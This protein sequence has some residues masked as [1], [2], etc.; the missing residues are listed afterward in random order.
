MAFN[1]YYKDELLFLREMGQEF[2]EAHP[3]AAFLAGRG[4]DPDVERLM[5]GFA[6]LTGR[7]RQKLDDEF[8][9]LTHGMMNVLWPH[10]LRPIPSM[11]IL[12]FSPIGGSVQGR[13][14][15]PRDTEVASVPVDGVPCRFRTTSQVELYP[16]LLDQA[17]LEMLPNGRTGLRLRFALNQGIALA[18]TPVSTIRLHLFG[19]PASELYLWLC[20]YANEITVRGIRKGK[21]EQEVRISASIRPVGFVKDEALLPYP[22]H[23]FDGYRL[24]QEYFTFPERFLFV[25]LEPLDALT[26][27]PA[28]EAFEICIGF[29]RPP[30][31]TLR[32]SSENLRLYCTPIVNLF[33]MDSDPLRIAHDRSEYRVRPAAPSSAFYEIYS[34]NEARGWTRG[35]AEERV[36]EPFYSVNHLRQSAEAQ[37]AYF[38]TRLRPSVTHD[39]SA[40]TYVSFVDSEQRSIVPPTESVACRLTCTNRMLPGKLRVGDIDV[41][42]DSSPEFATF[43]NITKPSIPIHPPLEGDLHWRLIS[44]LSLNYLSLTNV[45][46][47]RGILALYNFQSLVDRQ[48]GRANERRLDGL[49]AVQSKPETLLF[50]GTPIRGTMMTLTLRENHFANEGDVFLFGS[51][52]NEFL[53]T[54]AAINSWTQL[55]VKGEQQGEIYQWPARMG[56]QLLL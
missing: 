48:I 10:Y 40:D 45:E 21:P 52:M 33:E 43:R 37:P 28:G 24:L 25:D 41:P 32:L 20:R 36:Y 35:S 50:G 15:I 54:Y 22:R 14:I 29:S 38:E 42:T 27:I 39:E 47:L 49:T 16:F 5:E 19:E 31:P 2:A 7:I 55:T 12:Q 8:P 4:N 13:H 1:Q 30:S 44:H 9:E 56:R 51:V 46:A 53:A 17:K 3:E 18:Q 26:R 23:S 6:F 34:L 11:S